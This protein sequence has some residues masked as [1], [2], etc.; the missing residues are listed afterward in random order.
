MAAMTPDEEL[1][2]DFQNYS[3]AELE[4]YGTV[5]N[6]KIKQATKDDNRAFWEFYKSELDLYQCELRRRSHQRRN[7]N[8]HANGA[9]QPDAAKIELKSAALNGL[10]GDIVRAIEPYSE[11][12]RAALL[13]NTLAS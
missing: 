6:E 5:I 2:P 8:G 9:A 11:S 3:D 7:G 4:R 13:V 1:H 12:D 10:A